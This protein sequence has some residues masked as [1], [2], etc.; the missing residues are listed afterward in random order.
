LVDLVRQTPRSDLLAKAIELHGAGTDWRDLLAAAFLAG[1]RDVEPRP[2]GYQF[3]CV[4]MTSSAFEIAA[5]TP[6]RD[7]LAV[8]LYNLDDFKLSQ[9]RD[10]QGGDW[11]MSDAP[12]T[13]EVDAQK[14]TARLTEVLEKWDLEQA[15]RASVAL[16]RCGSL[17][18]AFEPLWWFGMR[19]FTNIGHNPIFTAQAHRTL[20]QIGWR[21]G[22]DVLRSLVYGLLDGAPGTGDETF[23]ANRERVGDV[24]LPVAG[25]TSRP[26]VASLE[27]LAELRRATPD[28]A[29]VA[30]AE[31][32]S[33]GLSL[34][35]FWDTLRLF[36]TEQQWRDPGLLAAH[37]VT[38]MN[39][40]RYI[41]GRTRRVET[42]AM[43]V[44]QAASWQVLYRDYLSARRS[45]DKSIVD[46]DELRP[47]SDRLGAAEL[48]EV[49]GEDR[50]R[51]AALAMAASPADMAELMAATRHWLVRK[52]REHHDYKYAAA[53]QEEMRAASPET[54]RRM[55]AVSLGY[56][57]RPDGR[58]HAL[59][60]HMQDG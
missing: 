21:Y 30:A 2:V 49:A 15:D 1:I 8:A 41:S 48:F 3:H 46:I 25:Q 17:D 31:A 60:A 29:A 18:V 35:S 59:W 58:D 52:V 4:M 50:H 20:Q 53:L 51:A 43:A 42:R 54:A 37:A 55:F 6:E 33:N 22:S 16:A 11:S 14:A 34:D 32:L 24:T 5:R 19:D 56:L 26:A 45:Y 39:A 27:L 44:L 47:A 23:V 36:A 13:D 7:R 10:A 38:S 40:L 28:Q 9:Q 12:T 57:R